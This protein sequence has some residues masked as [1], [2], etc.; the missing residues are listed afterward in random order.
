MWSGVLDSDAFGA[1]LENGLFDKTTAES[2]RRNIL[3]KSGSDD[4]MNLYVKFRGREPKTEALIQKL[5][6]N[7]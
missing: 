1:F 3:E 7:N 4:P 6:F 2:F 5:G